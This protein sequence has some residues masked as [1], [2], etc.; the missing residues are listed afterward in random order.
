MSPHSIVRGCYDNCVFHGAWGDW[1][2]EGASGLGVGFEIGDV[3]GW[4]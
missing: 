3:G 2:W 4:K 1:F